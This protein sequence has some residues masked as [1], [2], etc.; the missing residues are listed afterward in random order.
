MAAA[1]GTSEQ[2]GGGG[3]AARASDAAGQSPPRAVPLQQTSAGR[4]AGP[5]GWRA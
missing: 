4:P 5:L 2:A 3:G 1:R